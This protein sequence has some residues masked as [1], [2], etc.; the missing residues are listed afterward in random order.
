MS[1][2][3]QRP[4]DRVDWLRL[5]PAEHRE[6]I[7]SLFEEVGYGFGEVIIAEG[8]PAD[9]FYIITTGRA[10]VVTNGENGQELFLNNLSVGDQFGEIALLQGG[11]RTATVRASGP[12]SALKLSR[13]HFLAL[14]EHN[15]ALKVHLET[16]VRHRELHNYLRQSTLLKEAPLQVVSDLL[17]RL[18]PVNFR[19][20][21]KVI[22]QGDPAGPMY[23]VREGRLTVTRQ[24]DGRET[25]LAF[26]RAGDY[27]GEM[28]VLTG[29]PRGA[30]V[31]AF[32]DCELLGFSADSL[33]ELVGQNAHLASLV[34]QR[35]AQYKA[36]GSVARVPLDFHE[37]APLE[38]GPAEPAAD[39]EQRAENAAGAA[40]AGPSDQSGAEDELRRKHKLKR[41]RFVAQ[42]DEMDCGAAALTMVLKLHG[43]NL[44][45]AR[46][47]SK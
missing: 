29:A 36:Q 17:S 31:T 22:S 10:R 27:F 30:T 24:E 47:A 9:A 19:A 7:A 4:L 13:E 32:T 26:L 35:I 25:R 8:D 39:G 45:M 23:I 43:G 16:L 20:G 28:S 12:V 21:E 41:F 1:L 34:E 3:E 44:S 40:Q 5:L 38:D 11:R 15:P 2:A 6:K 42:A 18:H 37:A 33:Q 14:V 46:K